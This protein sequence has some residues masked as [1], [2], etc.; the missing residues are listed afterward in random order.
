[1]T[2]SR[3][4]R[5]AWPRDRQ[6]VCCSG[7]GYTTMG[8]G[9]PSGIQERPGDLA[10]CAHGDS[11]GPR[12]Q[13]GSHELT[14][15]PDSRPPYPGC[16]VPFVTVGA[17]LLPAHSLR[18][19]YRIVVVVE[20]PA[21]MPAGAGRTEGR[22]VCRALGRAGWWCRGSFGGRQMLGWAGVGRRWKSVRGQASLTGP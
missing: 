14:C 18:C 22:S 7:G 5:T 21:A 16:R 4:G 13:H 11:H 3:A 9:L 10:R 1:M 12:P 19:M 15:S 20:T 6:L 2:A 8:D 17:F